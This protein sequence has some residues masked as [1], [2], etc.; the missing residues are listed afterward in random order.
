MGISS[1]VYRAKCREVSPVLLERFPDDTDHPP[2]RSLAR[3]HST[4]Q[5]RVK[6][7]PY[8]ECTYHIV[9]TTKNY[10]TKKSDL[11]SLELLKWGLRAATAGGLA[12][13]QRRLPRRASRSAG[14]E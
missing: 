6:A 8:R 1:S 13:R 3:R 2:A 9:V 12:L 14:S 7:G 10:T 11:S 5:L 4:A